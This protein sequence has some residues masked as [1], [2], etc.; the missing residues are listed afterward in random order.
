M[1][2]SMARPA[3]LA[4]G[5]LAH[6][7]FA[8]LVS[9]CC[10]GLAPSPAG[11]TPIPVRSGPRAEG[12]STLATNDIPGITLQASS[13]F[14]TVSAAAAS[15]ED[16]V[17]AVALAQGEEIDRAL[18]LVPKAASSG[19]NVDVM[20]FGPSATHVWASLP[21]AH[22]TWADSTISRYP[23][24]LT[25]I[26]PVAGTYYVDVWARQGAASWCLDWAKWTANSDDALPGIGF[27]ASPLA[28]PLGQLTD[29]DD[30][31]QFT[32]DPYE[33]LRITCDTS[34][35]LD[36][37]V[38]AWNST[39]PIDANLAKSAAYD[40]ETGSASELV[41]DRT[42]ADP[43]TG[44]LQV[45]ACEGAGGYN[46]SWQ[47]L[48]MMSLRQSLG[49]AVVPYG[50]TSS[51]RGRLWDLHDGVAAAGVGVKLWYSYDN[52]YW[53][54]KYSDTTD[55][56]GAF[57]F[58]LK[59]STKTWYRTTMGGTGRIGATASSTVIVTPQAYLSAP[60]VPS[61]V[62]KSVGF[63]SSGY[64]KPRHA[65]GGRVVD[66]RCY[67]LENGAWKLRRNYVAVSSNYSSYTKYS[68][69][70]ILPYTGRWRLQAYH[71]SSQHAASYSSARYVTVR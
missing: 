32:L 10:L 59:P 63:T 65:A 2:V 22:S 43:A 62:K 52:T 6:A 42:P 44:S 50:G 69:R 37:D 57:A 51:L 18:N 46:M 54:S 4:K 55:A 68:A 25:F 27:P 8:A 7:I 15:S 17:Y 35:T 34:A 33:Q 41:L 26:A 3:C 36:A 38:A 45:R 24:Q 31:Y 39:H 64:L 49:E 53:Y 23:E 21:V 58:S 66:I 16:R 61:S 67:R 40:T 14:G 28:S 12:F 56:S 29:V 70:V 47:R 1:G 30:F 20:L 5:W 60:S 13:V 11:A 9:A 48:H 71:A 19:T